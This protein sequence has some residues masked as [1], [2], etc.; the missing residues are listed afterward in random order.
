MRWNAFSQCENVSS[1]TGNPCIQ[2]KRAHRGNSAKYHIGTMERQKQYVTDGCLG[3]ITVS[4]I[5]CS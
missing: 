3:N 1:F 5:L 4:D 2:E